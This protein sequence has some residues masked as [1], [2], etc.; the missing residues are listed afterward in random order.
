MCCL[1]RLNQLF[2]IGKFKKKKRNDLNRIDMIRISI[3]EI[4][5]YNISVTFGLALESNYQ[6]Q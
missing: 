4:L 1:N 3:F 2:E 6:F 5:T